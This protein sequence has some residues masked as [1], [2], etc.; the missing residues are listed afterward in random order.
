[1]T[2]KTMACVA[3]LGMIAFA[4]PSLSSA[5]PKPDDMV[6]EHISAHSEPSAPSASQVR[7]A[8]PADPNAVSSDSYPMH[9]K[10]PA[11]EGGSVVIP[12]PV[13]MQTP[14]VPK[15]SE[16]AEMTSQDA[17]ADFNNR[18]RDLVSHPPQTNVGSP[19]AIRMGASAGGASGADAPSNGIVSKFTTGMDGA[20]YAGN[21]PLTKHDYVRHSHEI[22]TDGEDANHESCLRVLIN[23]GYSVSRAE[24]QCSSGKGMAYNFVRN[25]QKHQQIAMENGSY[26]S[27]SEHITPDSEVVSADDPFH[28]IIRGGQ[29]TNVDTHSENIH[30]SSQA[31][32]AFDDMGT[33]VHHPRPLDMLEVNAPV[34]GDCDVS[35]DIRVLMSPKCREATDINMSEGIGSPVRIETE[36]DVEPEHV[37]SHASVT[38][39]EK[40]LCEYTI[41]HDGKADH[42]EFH[43]NTAADCVKKAI[44]E[45]ADQKSEIHIIMTSSEG[46]V[47]AA[48][49]TH[50]AN[51]SSSCTPE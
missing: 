13:N 22:D 42:G 27:G 39:K 45:S 35:K 4:F 12:S 25:S 8:L 11:Q 29:S 32:R 7:Q 48:R 38:P 21:A 44:A 47:S 23:N 14:A 26:S 37:Q 36:H 33:S 24:S 3:G 20:S 50:D 6:T 46:N 19:Y 15:P 49:C 1:M 30:I 51:N 40:N 31:T 16:D 2:K 43:P 28:Q 17:K 41:T 5:A 9:G 10:S 34:D 18:M